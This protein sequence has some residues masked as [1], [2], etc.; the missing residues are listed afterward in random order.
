MLDDS[1]IEAAAEVFSAA[2]EATASEFA[3][4]G[5]AGE[6]DFSGQLIGQLK[7]RFSSLTTATTQWRV[8]ASV[9]EREDGPAL[10]SVR[11]Q[12][13]QTSARSEEP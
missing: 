8:G 11:F 7:A 10:P 12:A 9:T 5:A 2:L 13:R 6:V 1:E 3:H 4:D